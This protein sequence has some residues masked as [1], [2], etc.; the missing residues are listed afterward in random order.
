MERGD[1]IRAAVNILDEQR[2]IMDGQSKDSV[3][4]EV[5]KDSDDQVMRKGSVDQEVGKGSGGKEVAVSITLLTGYLGAGKTTL[6]NHIL[7][8]AEGIRAAVIVNDIG[9]VNVDA[10]LIGKAAHDVG[11]GMGDGIVALTNGCICCTLRD[12]L[13]TTLRTLILSGSYDHIVVEASGICEPI[14]IAQAIT[15]VCEILHKEYPAIRV[16][17]D[18][19]IAVADARRLAD[20]F[21]CGKALLEADGSAEAVASAESDEQ[22]DIAVLLAE[23]LEFCNVVILNK[24]DCVDSQELPIIEEAVKA[25]APE[26]ELIPAVRGRVD[27]GRLLD[28]GSF[29]L[30]QA[31]HSAGWIQA[32]ENPEEPETEAYE[33]GIGTFV[34]LRRRA[35]DRKKF[36]DYQKMWPEEIIRCKGYLWYSDDPDMSVQFEQAG[37]QIDEIQGGW[38]IA[39]ADEDTVKSILEENP[40]LAEIWDDDCGDRMIQLV[41]IG[42]DMD[43]EAIEEALDNCLA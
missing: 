11:K 41:F 1:R 7:A 43:R 3:D 34:Y 9:E 16:G 8:N 40:G 22:E 39:A 5:R 2:K 4:Q 6:V 14:P 35:F 33:Y 15:E 17:L 37:R 12:D 28:T 31:R 19:V 21:G 30:E 32:L 29:D 10:K 36:L 42:R 23:Q 38:W 13:E 26:A 18:S 24:I 27:I 20:E 25:L